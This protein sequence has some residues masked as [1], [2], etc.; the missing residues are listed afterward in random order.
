M[1]QI[2]D[3]RLTEISDLTDRVRHFVFE[4]VSGAPFVFIPGQFIRIFLPHVGEGRPI[5]RSYS[6]A[7]GA[8]SPSKTIEFAASF[9][10]NGK[11]SE[12]LFGLS[13]GAVAKGSGP[14]GR[15]IVKEDDAFGRYVFVATNTGI[16]PY[17]SMLPLLEQKLEKNTAFKVVI[18]EGVRTR[19]DLLYEKDFLSLASKFPEQ[20]QFLACLSREETIADNHL[21]RG[22]VQNHFDELNIDPQTDCV[23]LCGNPEMIDAA[24]ESLTEKGLD[25]AQIRREKYI[26]N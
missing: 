16:T 8:G 25:I 3:L 20:V 10:E 23:Y 26:S 9:V 13:L 11:A 6:L 2:F 14:F 19:S 24:Y 22:Y 15:L 7:Q 5:T 21:R 4:P 18:M 17:R 1:P 12:Y